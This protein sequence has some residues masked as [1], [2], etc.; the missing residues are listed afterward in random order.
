MSQKKRLFPIERLRFN[1]IIL[2]LLE[3]DKRKS[4]RPCK[5]D[6]YHFFCGI[7]YVLRTGV[8]WRDL[9]SEFGN[10]HTI[11]TRY[12]RWCERGTFWRLLYHLQSKKI[13]NLDVIFVD[14]SIIPVHRHGSGALKK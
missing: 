8:S 6:T 14:G 11:Y 1:E 2:P 7:L 10:W 12:K 5:V 13:I 9:P 4:G 3:S